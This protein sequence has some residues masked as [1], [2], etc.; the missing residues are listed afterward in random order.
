[1]RG[2]KT[3]NTDSLEDLD[4]A[5]AQQFITTLTNQQNPEYRTENLDPG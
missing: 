5:P 4:V 1:M 2:K 3:K